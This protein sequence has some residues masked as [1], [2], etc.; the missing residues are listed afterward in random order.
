MANYASDALSE[1]LAIAQALS[2]LSRVRV[3]MALRTGELCACQLIELLELSPSTVSRHMGVLRQAGLVRQRRDG[4]W[5]HYR[6]AGAGASELVRGAL[7]WLAASL[8]SDP[9]LVA[10]RELIAEIR[11]VDKEELCRRH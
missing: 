4:R 9:R 11:Q 2:D 7:S 10:D 3:L 8:S 1:Q 6:L 5:T